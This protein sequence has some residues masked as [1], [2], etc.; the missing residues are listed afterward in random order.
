M[1]TDYHR[2]RQRERLLWRARSE[3][4]FFGRAVRALLGPLLGLVLVTLVGAV[5]NRLFGAPPCDL[6]PCSGPPTWDEAFFNSYSLLFLEHLEALPAHPVGQLVQ[7]VQPLF[8][9]FLLAEG[10]VKLGITVFRKQE[11]AEAWMEILARASRGHII[12][13]GVGTVGFRVLEELVRLGETVIA[14]ERDEH[15]P[16]L[17]RARD[18]G[19][20]VFVGDARAENVFRRLNLPAARAVIIA[21]NDDLANLEIAMDV[22][23]A[24]EKV[25]VVL[26]LF[27]QELAHK[28]RDVLEVDVS[29][30]TSSLAAP[31]FAS[32]ALDPSVVGTHRVGDELLVVSEQEVVAKS[33]LDGAV[34]SGLNGAHRLTVVALKRGEE[35]WLSQPPPDTRLRAGDRVQIMISSHRMNE[36]HVLNQPRGGAS[37]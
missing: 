18:L 25:P 24:R 29:V 36:I 16:F 5:L 9:I 33:A 28:V 34:L 6:P 14:V 26:R 7:Y 11:S 32:S 19:A 13:C 8:G 35:G 10:V 4:L 21:T 2:R 22:R 37:G 23:K 15:S 1:P 3:A 12:L 27:D 20:V 17:D 30:S 31:L